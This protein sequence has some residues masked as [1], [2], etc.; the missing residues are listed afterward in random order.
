M[1]SRM[2]ACSSDNRW[3][4]MCTVGALL[5]VQGAISPPSGVPS[6]SVKEAVNVTAPLQ[7]AGL[8]GSQDVGQVL[9]DCG[10]C[11]SRR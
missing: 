5:P 7:P 8:V 2:P 1:R 4:T 6:G 9:P 11:A 10:R 3:P